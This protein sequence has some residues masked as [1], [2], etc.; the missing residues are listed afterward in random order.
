MSERAR[1]RLVIIGLS[2]TDFAFFLARFIGHR[3]QFIKSQPSGD[4]SS[5]KN[6][7]LTDWLLVRHLAG[8]I[9]VGTGCRWN[10]ERR[11]FCT[12]YVIIDVDH[13]GDEADLNARYSRVIA[14]L[15]APTYVVKSSDSGGLHVYYFLTRSEPLHALRAWNGR[16]GDVMRL[17]EA[18]GLREE[19][20][21]IEVYPR[22]HYKDRGQ[23][24]RVRA[25][26][27]VGS[28]LLDPVTLSPIS[29][30]G[31]ASLILARAMFERGD[32]RL[33]DPMAWASRRSALAHPMKAPSPRPDEI[34]RRKRPRLAEL[35]K[36]SVDRAP[37]GH[38][39]T[40]VERWLTDGLTSQKELNKAAGALAFH[41]RFGLRLSLENATA[42]LLEWLESHHN[43]KSRT[44]NASPVRARAQ[45]SGVVERVYKR[46]KPKSASIRWDWVLVRGLS[47]FEARAVL[48]SL[49]QPSETCD[50][51]TGVELDPYKLQSYAFELLPGEA[52]RGDSQFLPR[53]KRRPTQQPVMA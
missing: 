23:Q 46:A 27:G 41:Y 30:P 52:V 50:P 16:D 42:R 15:G 21:S 29:E 45:V 3:W 6:E 10:D 36:R 28:C 49:E 11:I 1:D 9:V 2:L 25:P 53:S 26:F 38:H 7:Y 39:A 47:E 8:D 19:N 12:P 35:R 18:E 51:N 4:W 37:T 44:Y 32:V 34:P 33:V 24:N 31:P 22:G 5:R 48:T 17:L 43:G 13:N 20:G 40:M 14:A